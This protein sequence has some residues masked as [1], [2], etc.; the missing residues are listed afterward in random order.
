MTQ[1]VLKSKNK[2]KTDRHFILWPRLIRGTLIQ[3]YKRFLADVKLDNG[4]IVTAH[5]ANSGSM[6]ACKEPGNPVYLSFHDDPKRKLK[7]TW[8]IIEMD[9]SPVGVN[10]GWPNRLVA[11]AIINDVIAELTGYSELHSE[12]KVGDHSRLDLLLT[13]GNNKKCYIEVKNCTLVEDGVASFPDAVTQRGRKHLV[14]LQKLQKQGARCVMFYLVQRMDAEIFTPADTI[15][16]EY[17]AEL[18]KAREN[19]IEILV[20]DVSIDQTKIGIRNR[21][22]HKL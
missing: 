17:G 2:F 11:Q 13:D 9:T 20:Y 18:R 3:R 5:C 22:P 21:L 1:Q 14:E 19:G 8:E 16:P 6:K 15:D 4:T 12:V 7:Y 10:T